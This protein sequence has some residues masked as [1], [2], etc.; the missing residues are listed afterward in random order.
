M[1]YRF[2]EAHAV[3][4]GHSA[5]GERVEL[6]NVR[7][8][9]VAVVPQASIAAPAAPAQSNGAVAGEREAYL[10]DGFVRTPIYHR[11]QLAPDAVIEG[12][13]ILVQDDSTTVVHTGQTARVVD[14]GQLEIRSTPIMPKADVQSRATMIRGG[15]AALAGVSF[16]PQRARA[17]SAPVHL[18]VGTGSVEANAQLFYAVDMGFTKKNGLDV[19]V[20][21]LRSGTT[22][23]AA[24]VAGDLQCGVANTLSLGAAHQRNL[25]LV[26]IEGGAYSD[27]SAPTAQVVVAPDSTIKGAKD[28]NGKAVA[29]ISVGGLDQLAIDAYLDKN[30]GDLTSVKCIEVP[31]S[32]MAEALAQG[33]IS[34]ALMNDPELSQALDAKQVKAIAI[35]YDSIAKVFMQTA[36]F[37]TQDWLAQNKDVARRFGDAIIAGGQ[38]GMKNPGPAAAILAKYTGSKE[39]TPKGRFASKLDPGQI[40]PVYDAGLRYKLL[41]GPVNAVDFSW[42]GK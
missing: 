21:K 33:R 36:W 11:Q 24:I 23:M 16:F 22:T 19:E 12:P 35:G 3:L 1:R 31:P 34:A 18:R 32:A 41:P 15:A 29:V 10:G 42:N 9:S 17:Q 6:V 4:T 8:T 14:L 37:S 2:D 38:W 40:Q 5:P 20:V 26:M 39:A 7:V 13:A 30:G 27:A 28:L 25:P